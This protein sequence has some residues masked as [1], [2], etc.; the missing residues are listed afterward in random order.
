MD[1]F[2]KYTHSPAH[3]AVARRDHAALRRIVAALPRLPKAGEV[4]TEAESIAGE[5]TA[6]AVSAVIDRRDVPNRETPLHLAV[7]MRDPVAA[8]ILMS[9]GAD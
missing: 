3:L 1:D 4:T 8:D 2:S 5:T 9:A 7:R 6:D